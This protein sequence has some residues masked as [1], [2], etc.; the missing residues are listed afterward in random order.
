MGIGLF[1]GRRRGLMGCSD[2]FVRHAWVLI[3]VSGLPSRP[4]APFP[5]DAGISSDGEG[6]AEDE[7]A[8]SSAACGM[9]G[10]V[11]KLRDL[12][13]DQIEGSAQCS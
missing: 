7:G 11:A 6:G 8:A 1:A 4:P 2:R 5:P 13:L 3:A 10:A 9:P 12:F